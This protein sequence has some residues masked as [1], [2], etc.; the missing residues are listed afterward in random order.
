MFTAT[1]VD[2]TARSRVVI[3]PLQRRIADTDM[4]KTLPGDIAIPLQLS[5]LL[6]K[7]DPLHSR[8]DWAI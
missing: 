8:G 2:P 4:A 6:G 5:F 7:T 1:T 3:S